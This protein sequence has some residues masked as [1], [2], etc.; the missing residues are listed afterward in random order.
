MAD[1][2]HD[3]TTPTATDLPDAAL[4]RLPDHLNPAD[5]QMAEDAMDGTVSGSDTYRETIVDEQT[6][7]VYLLTFQD[8]SWTEKNDTFS[9]A[10][11]RTADGEGKLDFAQY[12]REIA[13]AKLV[14]VEPE[15][16][17]LRVWLQGLNS[18]LG[19]QLERHLPEPVEN[20]ED[21]REEN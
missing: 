1:Q 16:D 15:P 13:M 18:R 10:L 7:D 19:S 9:N 2:L 11:T 5:L 3:T 17:N 6:G 14:A 8:V 20:L 12:Y 4:A 21:Q